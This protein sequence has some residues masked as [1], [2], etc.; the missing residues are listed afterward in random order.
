MNKETIDKNP[1]LKLSFVFALEIIK[2]CDELQS[3]KKFVIAQQL[4]KSGTTI[5]ANAIEAQ[6]SESKADFIHTFKVA[7]KEGEEAEY[8]LLLCDLL[9]S[10]PNYNH[11]LQKIESINRIIGK[12]ISTTKKLNLLN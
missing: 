11:L 7:A 5:C 10:Y 4:L 6:N 3:Q 8:F 9:N 2:F 12:I 1:I